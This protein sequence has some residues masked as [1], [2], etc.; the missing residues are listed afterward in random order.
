MTKL[1]L[2]ITFILISQTAAAQEWAFKVLLDNKPIG[3]HTFTLN[4]ANDTLTSNAKFDVKLLFINA[5]RYLH[6]SNETWQDD[7]LTSIEANTND[8][9]KK[10]VVVGKLEGERF[11]LNTTQGQQILPACIMTFAYWNP[12]M[13][14]QSKLLNPQTGDFLEVKVTQ[15]VREQIEVRGKSINADH[16]NVTAKKMNIDLWYSPDKAWLA[17]RST[18]PEGRIINYKLK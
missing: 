4:E 10:S 15:L 18:T 1:T 9:G 11:V 16:F 17:L 14:S 6:V 13:L 8:N 3:E 7:C 12:K 2:F 5:Y